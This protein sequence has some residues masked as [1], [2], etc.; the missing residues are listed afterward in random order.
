MR[1]RA[2]LAIGGFGALLVG[3]ALA[4]LAS[5][6]KAGDLGIFDLQE[7]SLDYHNH[8]A[9]NPNQ[10]D[11]L[12]FPESPK[13]KM[14]LNV[15]TDMLWFLGL[16]TQLHAS[17]TDSQY[18]AVG[19]QVDLYA[20]ITQYLEVGYEHH[21]QHL[22]DRDSASLPRFPSEDSLAVKLYLF[23]AKVGRNSLF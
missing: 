13:E 22:L 5:D 18:R 2:T 9:L 23:R 12:L 3:I 7:V 20:R 8:A 6:A 15:K 4:L 19:L 1:Y 14:A 16:D 21:S 17:T 11:P 10:R